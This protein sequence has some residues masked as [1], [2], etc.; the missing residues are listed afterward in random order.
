[1]NDLDIQIEV[2]DSDNPSPK[3]PV[4]PSDDVK[5]LIRTKFRDIALMALPLIGLPNPA[6]KNYKLRFEIESTINPGNDRGPFT[7]VPV[8]TTVVI[9]LPD[10]KCINYSEESWDFKNTLHQLAHECVHAF[11][12]PLRIPLTILEEGMAAYFSDYYA[13]SL[14]INLRQHPCSN[15]EKAKYAV[16]DLLDMKATVIT[17]LR[18]NNPQLRISQITEDMLRNA[19][20]SITD[21][22][23]QLL[24]SEFKK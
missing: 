20:P 1:M 22:L 10:Y 23:A 7:F 13:Q 4:Q 5:A 2:T 14:S 24:A 9:L 18:I 15:H 12:P 21:S 11:G 8:D 3:P 16:R 6:F 17:E 19:C